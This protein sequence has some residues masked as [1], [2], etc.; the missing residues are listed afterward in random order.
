MLCVCCSTP[1]WPV[2][3]CCSSRKRRII[4]LLPSKFIGF[5][6][7]VET[8]ALAILLFERMIPSSSIESV[9][10][11]NILTFWVCLLCVSWL[12]S[13]SKDCC[14]DR[15]KKKFSAS[16]ICWSRVLYLFRRFF[17]LMTTAL[18][19]NHWLKLLESIRSLSI[20]CRR[21]SCKLLSALFMKTF[22]C[23]CCSSVVQLSLEER[24]ISG[25][26]NQWDFFLISDTVSPLV[27]WAAGCRCCC[28]S[29]ADWCLWDPLFRQ[30][31]YR[32]ASCVSIWSSLSNWERSCCHS[33]ERVCQI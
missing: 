16:I 28:R 7:D 11:S 13:P 1:T 25:T 30:F 5:F 18:S 8:G 6:V 26:C 19:F 33:I 10:W 17:I 24:R 3:L 14:W 4:L 20:G 27:R 29:S 9:N 12:T 2:M 32:C 23:C 22:S 21:V 15:R 31:G